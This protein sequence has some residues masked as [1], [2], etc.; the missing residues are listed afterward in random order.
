MNQNL[1]SYWI[2]YTV[3]NAGNI[4]RAA[5]E[6]FISQ[7]AISKSIQKLE[8][9][10]GCKLFSRSSR[11]VVLTDEGELLYNH[12]SE[13]FEV[14]N[15]GEEKLRQS[16]EMGMGHLNI[17]CTTSLCKN[18]LLPYL[19]VF[20]KKYPHISISIS[21]QS[22]YETLK[23]LED[24]KID[25]GLICRPVNLKN[26]DFE[27]VD[28]IE[29]VFLASRDYLRNMNLLGMSDP[30]LL[31][32]CTLMLTDKTDINRQIAERYLSDHNIVPAD[33]IEITNMDLAIE[34]A[35]IGVGI[36]AVVKNFALDELENGTLVQLPFRLAVEPRP[37]GFVYKNSHLASL[38]LKTFI[39]FFNVYKEEH[40]S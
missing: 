7:P 25:I 11:G 6:L 36:A 22:S 15:V 10:I 40:K 30:Q 18:E 32:H 3:A 23:L 35:K 28:Y 20:I 21:C 17:G 34:F 31:Q 5:K 19:K 39:E 2:F 27:P 16:V 29:D 9:S 33:I 8:E 24:N 4:S 38:S 13:A 26:I 1:S 37:V 14:L 12:V